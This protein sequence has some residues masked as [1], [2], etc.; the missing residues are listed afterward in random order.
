MKHFFQNAWFITCSQDIPGTLADTGHDQMEEGFLSFIRLLGTVY[1]KKHLA[2][3][4]LDT[5][6]ALYMSLAQDGIGPVQQHKRFIEVIRESVWSRIEFEDEFP[7]SFDALWRH[8][9]RTCWVSNMWKQAVS[10]HMRVLDLTQHG[11]KIV[12]GKLECDWESVGNREAVRQQVGL[13][14]R[15]CSCSSVVHDDAV[16]SRRATSVV[17]VVGVRTVVMLPVPQVHSNRA[18][19]S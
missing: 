6:R 9:Q 13:L 1:F 16:V 4:T 8:W 17:P 12:D 18:Q 10:N 3:F 19:M 14:F 5:P 11:W 2:E 15:G 7:P